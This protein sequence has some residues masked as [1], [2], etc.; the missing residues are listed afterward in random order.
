MTKPMK[1]LVA[2]DGS[3][4]S[5]EALTDLQRAGLPN[6]V[7]AIV[8]CVADIWVLPEG[9]SVAPAPL[10]P[11]ATI[12]QA[13]QTTAL[14]KERATTFAAHAAAR[15]QTLFPGWTVQA[16]CATDSPAWAIIQKAEK[17]EADLIVVGS[18]GYSPLGRWVL[19]SVSQTVLTQARTSVRIARGRPTQVNRPLRIIVGVDGSIEADLA[20]RTVAHRKWPPGT[21][22]RLIMV[23]NPSVLESVGA[24][25]QNL[26]TPSQATPAAAYVMAEMV[27]D[28]VM[29]V[30]EIDGLIG[31][32]LE[33]YEAIVNDNSLGVTVSTLLLSGDPKRVLLDEAENWGADCIF[34]GSRGL[35]RW[36]RLLLGSVSNAVAVRAHC[37]VEV[38]RLQHPQVG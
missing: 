29:D 18:H 1:V 13:R 15:L 25:F 7:E 10:G 6:N 24:N 35:N 2:Y 30:E 3:P 36:E 33:S 21:D 17:W 23:L 9:E 37:P 16:E 20:V 8:M 4:C 11:S 14:M 32:M 27:D 12:R 38:V 31:R 5:E 28:K 34:I 26:P 22:I 19:G